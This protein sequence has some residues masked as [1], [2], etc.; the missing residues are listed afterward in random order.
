MRGT[1]I[2]FAWIWVVAV[3]AAYLIQ[4]APLMGSAMRLVFGS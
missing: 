4:F 3:L 2:A 1:A